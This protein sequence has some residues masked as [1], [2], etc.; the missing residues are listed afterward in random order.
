MLQKSNMPRKTT[1]RKWI[2]IG[3]EGTMFTKTTYVVS[4]IR[5]KE[6]ISI[7]SQGNYN[8]CDHRHKNIIVEHEMFGYNDGRSVYGRVAT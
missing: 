7:C 6:A 1:C 2:R 5:E 4:N 3:R 8:N